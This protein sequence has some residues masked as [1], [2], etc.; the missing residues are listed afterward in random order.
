MSRTEPCRICRSTVAGRP[1]PFTATTRSSS[2]PSG[3][4]ATGRTEPNRKPT[5]SPIS[6]SAARRCTTS[7]ENPLNCFVSTTRSARSS[8]SDARTEAFADSPKIAT[9]STSARPMTSALAVAAVR[10]GLRIALPRAIAPVTPAAFTGS[11]KVAASGRANVASNTIT[12]KNTSSAPSPT[13]RN[14][15]RTSSASC[16][17]SM[18]ITSTGIPIATSAPPSSVRRRRDTSRPLGRSLMA[19][20]GGTVDARTAG[21][22]DAPTVTNIPTAS[23]ATMVRCCRTS[24]PVGTSKPRPPTTSNRRRARRTPN[25]SPAIDATMPTTAAST[26]TDPTIW[27]RLAPIARRRPSSR[28]RWATRIVKVLKMMNAATTMPMAAKPRSTPVS[29]SRNSVMSSP[30]CRAT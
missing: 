4:R 9:I 1:L 19:A 22:T 28:V 21:H 17:R 13:I 23:A 8:P 27:R 10:R 25:A 24:S 12:P 5:A 20:T 7:G 16:A 29:R 15:E 26:T 6:G 30:L 3:G 2:S 18:P 11:P 14:A